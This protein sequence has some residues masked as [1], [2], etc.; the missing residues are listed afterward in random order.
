MSTINCRPPWPTRE[1]ISWTALSSTRPSRDRH[2]HLGQG[3]SDVRHA[4]DCLGIDDKVAARIGLRLYKVGMV[5][6]EPEGARRFAEACRRSSSSRRSGPS[7]AGLSALLYNLGGSSRP[8]S[9]VRPTLP[10]DR[11]CRP[12]AKQ[13]RT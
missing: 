9:I 12:M 1:P 11:C 5:A 6:R 8:R 10:E 4:L 2:R 13:T 7:S 3:L